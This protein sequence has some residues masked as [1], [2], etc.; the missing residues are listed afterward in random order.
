MA[1]IN[2][3]YMS[4]HDGDYR[5]VPDEL[6]VHDADFYAVERST[7][8]IPTPSEWVRYERNDELAG[9]HQEREIMRHRVGDG[10]RNQRK[11]EPARKLESGRAGQP[12]HDPDGQE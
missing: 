10:D 11:H 7:E 12:G 6:C 4:G 9:D 3:K 5:K 1:E 8:Q 2:R